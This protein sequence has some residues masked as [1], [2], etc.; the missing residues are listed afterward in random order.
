MM[1]IRTHIS[2]TPVPTAA[3]K[4]AQIW[5]WRRDPRSLQSVQMWNSTS[6]IFVYCFWYRCDLEKHPHSQQPPQTSPQC[7]CC[8]Q[9]HPDA[10]VHITCATADYSV[11][12]VSCWWNGKVFWKE[13]IQRDFYAGENHIRQ[14][15]NMLVLKWWGAMTIFSSS[16]VEVRDLESNLATVCPSPILVAHAQTKTAGFCSGFVMACKQQLLF[17]TDLHRDWTEGSG[18]PWLAQFLQ[19]PASIFP[20]ERHG[21]SNSMLAW[22][23]IT[24]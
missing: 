19:S 8:C 20:G 9:I 18:W 1:P 24:R 15:S 4:Q 12:N 6:E 22:D 5:H 10:D 3:G 16:N 23:H 7:I 21:C 11:Q 17:S 14:V 13:I 2:L